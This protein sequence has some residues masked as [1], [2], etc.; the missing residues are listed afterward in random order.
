MRPLDGPAANTHP[1]QN[2]TPIQR[3]AEPV[4]EKRH[5]N[6]LPHWTREGATYAVTFRLADSLPS[7]VL[8]SWV[9]E[10]RDIVRTA[11]QM[12]R[13]LSEHEDR[14]LR[15]LHSERVEAWLDSGHGACWMRNPEVAQ[16]V[17]DALS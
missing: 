1:S 16:V 3:S 2:E 4:I 14:K 11:E 8:K 15:K 5:G 12:N 7:A 9:W 17:A 6:Y 13:P 10:R